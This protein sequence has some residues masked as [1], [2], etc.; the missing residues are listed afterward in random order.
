VPEK[1]TK[2]EEKAYMYRENRKYAKTHE[3]FK[4]AIKPS[5]E[6]EL[7]L[8]EAIINKE[9]VS[10]SAIQVERGKSLESQ[11]KVNNCPDCDDHHCCLRH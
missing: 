11:N 10:S 4:T 7:S 6:P 2:I 1:L 3:T 9:T 5:I 8:W